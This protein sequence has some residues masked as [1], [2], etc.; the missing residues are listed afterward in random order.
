MTQIYPTI[1]P[2]TSEEQHEGG[3]F[4]KGLILEHG[5]WAYRLTSGTNDSLHVFEAGTLIYVLTINLHLD[6]VSLDCYIGSETD[7]VDSVFLQGHHTII[8]CL[9]R[10]WNL[11]PLHRLV[12]SLKPYFS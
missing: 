1:R 12:T 8:E 4:N 7:P 10:G 9:G 3:L 2:M 6:Y 5:K 11:M